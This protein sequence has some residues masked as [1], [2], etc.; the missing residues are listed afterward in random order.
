VAGEV[1]LEQAGG[2]AAAAA[3][4]SPAEAVSIAIWVV[5]VPWLLGGCGTLLIRRRRAWSRPGPTT[6]LKARW[7]GIFN[8]AGIHGTDETWSIGHAVS[9]G[10][11]R[12]TIPDVINLYNQVSVGTPVYIG[13]WRM[14]LHRCMNSVP[15]ASSGQDVLSRSPVSFEQNSRSRCTGS[16]DE[17]P[18]LMGS[19]HW[20]PSTTDR[21]SRRSLS[22]AL[23]WRLVCVVD[24]I[25][26]ATTPVYR[27]ARARVKAIA[28]SCHRRKGAPAFGKAEI[29][30]LLTMNVRGRRF[31]RRSADGLARLA[32]RRA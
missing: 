13:D 5:A 9:H 8:G 22:S 29:D 23:S 6:P 28:W 25:R 24:P 7:L 11:V 12:M 2:V 16:R 15:V 30:S 20:P 21:S 19:H 32:R 26:P 31:M 17:R 18:R 14:N 10:C 3:D 27:Y 1:A 4:L